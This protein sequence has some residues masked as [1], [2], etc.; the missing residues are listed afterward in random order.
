MKVAIIGATGKAGGL[1]AKEAVAHGHTVT[2]VTRPASIHKLEGNYDV[3]PK[4]LYDLTTDDLRGFDI[5][6]DAFGTDFSKPGTEY[7]H[8]TS[9]EHLIEIMEPIP[10]VRLF[11]IGGAGSLFTDETRTR[12]I[13]DSMSPAIR[14]VPYN[15]YLAWL[16]LS[17]SKVNYT[18]MSPAEV[19][20]YAGP[21]TGK[22]QLGGD[23]K[24]TNSVGLSYITYSDFAVAMVDEFENKNYV[25]SRFTAVSESRY[26]N[27]GKNF[28]S[29]MGNPFTRRGSY[30]GIWSKGAT[31]Y[32]G[33]QICIGSRRGE[34]GLR[35][36]NTLVDIAPIYNGEKIP[37]AVMTRPDE[38]YLRTQYGN[39]RICMP[40][41]GLMYFKGENGLGLRIDKE[42]ERHELMKPRG[43]KGGWEGIFRQTCSLVF[44]PLKG[45]IDMDARW[46]WERLSTP[47]VR[48]DILPDENGELLLSV[49]EFTHAGLVRDSYPTWEEGLANVRA[50]WEEFLS[51]QPSLGVAYEEEREQAAYMT[52]SHIV[53]P[54][55]RIKR[56]LLYMM[57]TSCASSWQ[58]CEGAVA[59][60]NNLP[61]AIE[62]M[63][64]PFDE[65][66][67]TGRIPD[68]YDSI[69]GSYMM[70]KP[71]LQGWALKILMKE[72]DFATEVP[73]EKLIQLYDGCVRWADWFFKYRDDD[74][75][76][77]PQYEHGDESGND[78]AAI[79]RE[80]Y[81]IKLPDLSALLV[82]L[83]EALGD[84]AKILGR[85]DEAKAHYERSERTLKRLLDAFWNGKRFIGLTVGDHKVVDTSS[86]MFFRPMLLGHRLPKEIRDKMIED[87]TKEGT[88]LT[89][90]GLMM[91]R[92]DSLDYNRA[93]FGNAG[94]GA[95]DNMLI[96]TGLYDAGETELA[97]KLARRFCDGVKMG[98]SAYYGVRAG[99]TGSWVASAFQVLANLAEN[100]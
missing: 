25:K 26:K 18:F 31:S 29:L 11:V 8:V 45:S 63:L 98:G 32:G 14:A 4:D 99:F 87:L 12:R 93:S 1:I 49:E 68:L 33:A 72:H 78:D 74:G 89:P 7:Q 9:V 94:V 10:E 71:P 13:L 50:D 95:S 64:N 76:G 80:R 55:G 21:R 16:K 58:M 37:F 79:F 100:G 40:E 2:A 57:G 24:I 88:Y 51:H 39:I 59:L 43:D 85:E 60:K 83:D 28:F 69:K 5:V 22:Y 75:D 81:D 20:D 96:I 36:T 38:L 67:D 19:F 41:T 6:V 56:P 48:G 3:I 66:A 90:N 54:C 15:S 62:L 27:D 92:I 30:F 46:D 61:L 82:V 47:I 44:Q 91:M 42:M 77:L 23:V 73:R 35:P 65:Q 34:V 17:A 52:W 70:Y 86:V 84:I 53:D 97:K